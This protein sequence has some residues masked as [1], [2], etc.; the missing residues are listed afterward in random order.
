MKEYEKLRNIP[1]GVVASTCKA[2][3]WCKNCPFHSDH[4][5]MFDYAS[6]SFIYCLAKVV[7]DSTVEDIDVFLDEYVNVDFSNE[8]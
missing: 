5:L 1:F 8:V 2:Q 7:I 4:P 3:P 6:N